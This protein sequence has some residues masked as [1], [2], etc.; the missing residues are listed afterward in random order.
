ML[1]LKHLLFYG[2][3]VMLFLVFLM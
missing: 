2:I 3:S 1:K